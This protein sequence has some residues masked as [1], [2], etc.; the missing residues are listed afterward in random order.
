MQ[1]KYF[2]AH[3][4]TFRMLLFQCVTVI[5]LLLLLCLYSVRSFG[6]D[7]DNIRVSFTMF[8]DSS[9]FVSRSIKDFNGNS[10]GG[11]IRRL[12]TRIISASIG[13]FVLNNLDSPVRMYMRPLDV[14]M[15]VM[16][17]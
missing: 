13:D 1:I 12:N 17:C 8:D 15:L 6:N 2:R 4:T 14:S 10:D 11:I 5:H 3:I 16:C 7:L 9:L